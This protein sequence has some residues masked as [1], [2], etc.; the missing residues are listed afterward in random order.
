MNKEK[1]NKN[2][3][4]FLEYYA[5][6]LDMDTSAKIAGYKTPFGIC[7]VKKF[8]DNPKGLFELEKIIKAGISKLEV[9][10][11]FIVKKYLQIIEYAFF[12]DEGGLKDPQ[13][14]LRA[15]DG[16]CKQLS[17]IKIEDV[18][19]QKS[20]FESIEGLDPNKI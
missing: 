16:L 10:K 7:G 14:G 3:K 8:L 13:L 15:L 18:K 17:C 12:E 19:N 5:K 20:I 1:I 6:T 9:T 11:A 2:Q 4:K